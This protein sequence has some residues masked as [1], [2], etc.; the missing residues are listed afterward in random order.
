[1]RQNRFAAGLAFVFCAALSPMAQADVLS[2]KVKNDR[3]TGG[4]IP[5]VAVFEYDRDTLDASV[6]YQN[7]HG[8]QNVAGEVVTLNNKRVTMLFKV[9]GMRSRTNQYLPRMVYRA[10]YYYGNKSLKVTAKPLGF[11]NSFEGYGACAA[12]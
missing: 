8:P 10:T 2:C 9:E 3:S 6:K 1:M 12:S 11:S 7:K 5:L 4:W